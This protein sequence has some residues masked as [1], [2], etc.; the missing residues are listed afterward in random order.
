MLLARF[1]EETS[2][3]EIPDEFRKYRL[4]FETET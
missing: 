1:S 4:G 3:L 2:K